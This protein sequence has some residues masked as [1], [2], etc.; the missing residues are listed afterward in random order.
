MRLWLVPL[1]AAPTRSPFFPQRGEA[2]VQAGHGRS[3]GGQHLRGEQG[4][5]MEL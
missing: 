5:K 3:G 1:G 4:G 2:Q